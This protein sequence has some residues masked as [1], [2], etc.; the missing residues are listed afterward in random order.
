MAFFLQHKGDVLSSTVDEN[1][2]TAILLAWYGKLNVAQLMDQAASLE[3]RQLAPLAA[4]LY[5][6]WL[7][8]NSTPQNHFIWFNLGV[9]LFSQGDTIGA[10]NA[11][12]QAIALVSNFSQPRFNL[13]LVEE[14][15]GNTDAAIQHW[16]WVVDNISHEDAQARPIVVSSLNNLGRVLEDKRN[17]ALASEYLTQ[18]LHLEPNQP[19]VLHHWIFLREKQCAWPIYLPME[20]VSLEQLRASTSALAMLSISDNPEEQ[21][22]A[23]CNYSSKKIPSDLPKL[24]PHRNYGHRKIRIGYCSSDFCLHPVALLTAEL[25][26]CHNRDQFEIYGFCWSPEDGSEV[27]QR[28][29]NAMDH[30]MRIGTLTD[31]AAAQLIREHEIDILV[32]LHGQTKGARAT[33][34]AYRPAPIQVTYLGLPATTGLPCVDYVIADEFLIPRK[35]AKFYSEKPLYMPDVYQV[36]D[37]RRQSSPPP[38]RETCGLPEDAFVFCCFNNNYKYTPEVFG[39]WLNILHR[40]PNSILWLLSDNQWSESNLRNEAE[41]RGIDSN[42]LIF[43]PRVS[44]ADYLARFTAADLFLDSFPFNA[45]TTAND[46]LWMGLPVL[47]LSGR[48]FASRMA[49]ALLTAAGLESLITYNLSDYENKAV[50]LAS[51]GNHCQDLKQHLRTIQEHGVL[52]DTALFTKNLEGKFKKLVKAL[53]H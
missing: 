51:A 47:T 4:V 50:E 10:K 43:S 21:L 25:F 6:T 2:S 37:R 40:V 22:T 36:S 52:F 13:G 33:I 44:P 26:E 9:S 39:A 5:D 46:A 24:A 14:R 29:I 18:S 53:P 28:I 27:R 35:L 48:S 1:F 7:K 34:L 42:R 11:Y 20:G 17:Y 12:E 8:R 49:G 15:L 3:A 23:A 38:T 41:R 32:D 31:E 30:F 16:R 45:G 19:E